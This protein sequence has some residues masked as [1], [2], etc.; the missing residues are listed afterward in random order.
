MTSFQLPLLH[1]NIPP[2]SVHHGHITTPSRHGP[3]QPISVAP[4]LHAP[5]PL[6]VLELL[7]SVR[8]SI[9]SCS[10]VVGGFLSLAGHIRGSS[11]P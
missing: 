2:D 6:L 4:C 5:L 11:P 8:A 9:A 10:A 3:A 7:L 1:V